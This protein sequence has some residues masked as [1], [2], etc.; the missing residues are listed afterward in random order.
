MKSQDFDKYLRLPDV[1][2]GHFAL[3]TLPET[4]FKDAVV[5]VNSSQQLLTKISEIPKHQFWHQ[6][7]EQS[8]DPISQQVAKNKIHVSPKQQRQK[9]P[10]CQ[11]L[12]IY[13][14]PGPFV[15]EESIKID[16]IG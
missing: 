5:K 11:D 7:I 8:K 1:L 2:C 9:L 15:I 6:I 12:S 3:G 14:L 10:Q 13:N 16:G 4:Y